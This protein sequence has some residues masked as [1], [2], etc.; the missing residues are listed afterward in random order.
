MCQGG[1]KK[2]G[3]YRKRQIKQGNAADQRAYNLK[4]NILWLK[5]TMNSSRIW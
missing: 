4:S 3:N 2:F 5:A 1:E